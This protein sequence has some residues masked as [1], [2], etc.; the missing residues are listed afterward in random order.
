MIRINSHR[1]VH[2][3]SYLTLAILISAS[4][5]A[6]GQ[7]STLHHFGPAKGPDGSLPSPFVGLVADKAGNL[8][9]ATAHG[10]A[11]GWGTVFEFSPPAT[12]GPWTETILYK[13]FN[14]TGSPGPGSGGPL[15]FDSAGNLYGETGTSAF[16][17]VPPAVSGDPW[18]L[19]V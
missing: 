12:T 15:V 19:N 11:F 16:Q 5:T 6:L 13:N 10:G 4:T 3:L 14:Y 2:A 8:Y 18:T 17:L 1:A 9:G 7:F